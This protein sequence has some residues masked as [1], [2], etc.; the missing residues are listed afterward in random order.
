[1]YIL[2]VN[3][4]LFIRTV[5]SYKSFLIIEFTCNLLFKKK[6][7][8]SVHNECVCCSKPRNETGMIT[9]GSQLT[10]NSDNQYRE[11]DQ[12]IKFSCYKWLLDYL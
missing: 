7:L 4:K 6:C 12:S 3:N 11:T 8:S 2:K 9:V 1:M 5:Y 10:F